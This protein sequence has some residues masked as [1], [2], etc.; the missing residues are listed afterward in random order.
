[1]A[2]KAMLEESPGS[3]ETRRRITSARR[4]P[5]ESA[6]ESRPPRTCSGVRGKGW[7]KS[8]PRGRQRP[9]HGKPRLEQ[10]RIG[11]AHGPFPARAPGV[12]REGP[13]DRAPR[14]MTAQAPQGAGQNPAYRPSGQ[15][16]S[17]VS[18]NAPSAERQDAPAAARLCVHGSWQRPG[19][20][21]RE[22]CPSL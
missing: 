15:P 10:D 3:M 22:S 1:M 7:G 12:S 9:W 11:G 18:R 17:S 6:T 4:K 13:G 2:H 16:I 14:G 20:F 8:P 21:P 5:R 19:E